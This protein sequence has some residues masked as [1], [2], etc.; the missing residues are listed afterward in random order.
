MVVAS[1]S[2]RKRHVGDLCGSQALPHVSRQRCD[3]PVPLLGTPQI[4]APRRKAGVQVESPRPAD[5]GDLASSCLQFSGIGAQVP[6]SL[7]KVCSSWALLSFL[8][9]GVSSFSQTWVAWLYPDPACWL[10][11]LCCVGGHLPVSLGHWSPCSDG[12][13]LGF[14]P[15]PCHRHAPLPPWLHASGHHCAV[16]LLAPHLCMTSCPVMCPVVVC[17]RKALH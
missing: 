2:E 6:G 5:G 8:G 11:S 12:P 13:A 15:F 1:Y 17:E 14:L 10:L 7:L 4:L 16:W 3:S 9:P